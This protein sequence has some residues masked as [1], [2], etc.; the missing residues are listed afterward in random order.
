MKK[1]LKND[2]TFTDFGIIV[3]I[4]QLALVCVEC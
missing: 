1:F 4:K 2:L 3:M